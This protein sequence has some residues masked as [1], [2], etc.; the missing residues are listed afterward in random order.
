MRE[1]ESCS[2]SR[3]AA[4]AR[5]TG[6]P[7]SARSGPARG[8]FVT[9]LACAALLWLGWRSRSDYWID[10]RFGLGYALGIAGLA[11]MVLLLLYSLRKRARAL[12]HA[13]SLRVWFHIHMML[14]LLGPTA[15]LL[16]ANFRLGSHNSTMALASMLLVAGSGI[17]GRFIYT[18]IHHEYLGRMA[19]L[20][21]L[22]AEASSG[23]GALGSL[24][25]LT[26]ELARIMRD[27]EA[28]LLTPPRNPAHGAWRFLWAGSI[29]RAAARRAWRSSRH[30]LCALEHSN[31]AAAMRP[32]DARRALRAYAAAV[33]RAARFSGYARAFSVWHLLHLPLCVLLFG[34]ALVHI[35][36]VHV[37]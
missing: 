33:R 2:T 28:L 4:P 21:E 36:A 5:R 17:V 18:K 24:A 25:H 7:S 34:A 1:A 19:T 31:R 3:P 14:G 22:R 26:P 32:G 6:E 30:A 15:I 13:G 37:F 11:M 16:H 35:I 8:P 12:R 10:A 20:G 9:G 29:T 27:L 23:Y